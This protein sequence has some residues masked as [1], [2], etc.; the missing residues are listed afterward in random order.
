MVFFRVIAQLLIAASLMLLGADAVVSLES[1]EISMRT[2]S[3]FSQLLTIGDLTG[4][5]EQSYSMSEGPKK[6]LLSIVGAPA[7]AVLGLIGMLM[8]WIFADRG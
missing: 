8:A 5:L 7:W 4:M 1:G 6:L 3:E 2:I